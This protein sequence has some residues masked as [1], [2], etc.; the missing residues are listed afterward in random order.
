MTDQTIEVKGHHW[1]IT[2]LPNP[3]P[4]NPLEGLSWLGDT[5]EEIAEGLRARGIKGELGNDDRCPL[6]NY[7][8]EWWGEAWVAIGKWSRFPQAPAEGECPN[9]CAVF[10][11]QFDNRQFP[12][13]ID[14]G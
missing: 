14:N 1:K 8:H 12:D 4:S 6:A 13:L 5:V 11:R 10:E 2:D 7:L 9:A 3:S